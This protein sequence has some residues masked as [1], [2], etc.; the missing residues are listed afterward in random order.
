MKR[1]YLYTRI[2]AVM[3]MAVI[4]GK[5]NAQF[6]GTVVDGQTNEPVP[7]VTVR[8]QNTSIGAITDDNG[9]F[10]VPVTPDHDKL[11]I[12]AVGY[13]SKIVV[14]NYGKAVQKSTIKIFSDNVLLGDVTVTTKKK[15]Y[16]RK[17]NPAVQL[18]KKVIENKNKYQIENNDF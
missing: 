10:E 3:A 8:Y 17:E 12:S 15:K 18:M 14:V 7:Y 2:I 9:K 11:E 1:L 13:K 4:A 5:C 6:Y 16:K